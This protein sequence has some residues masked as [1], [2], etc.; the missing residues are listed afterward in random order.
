MPGSLVIRM[1]E[2]PSGLKTLPMTST[3]PTRVE[4]TIL[5]PPVTEATVPSGSR[6]AARSTPIRPTSSPSTVVNTGETVTV[7][8]RPSRSIRSV[9]GSPTC[10]LVMLMS[11]TSVGWSTPS[12]PTI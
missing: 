2:M 12:M 7:K 5:A 11:S 6:A 4:P 1:R 3:A 8:T 10:V 9:T